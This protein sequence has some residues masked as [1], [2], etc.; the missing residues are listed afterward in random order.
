MV[1]LMYISNEG[2]QR[3]QNNNVLEYLLNQERINR[4]DLKHVLDLLLDVLG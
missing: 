4:F 3:D 2:R 1:D